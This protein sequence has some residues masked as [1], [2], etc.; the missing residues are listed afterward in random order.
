[1]RGKFISGVLGA[2]GLIAIGCGPQ[3]KLA[4]TRTI[5]EHSLPLEFRTRA[6]RTQFQAT[7]R[8]PEIVALAKRIA[9]F[10]PQAHYTA[11]GTSAQGRPLPMLVLSKTGDFTPEQHAKSGKLLALF[12]SCIHPGEC[13][14]K[15]AS[16]MLARDI[17]VTGKH[18]DLLEH[19][20]IIF[21]P[22]F[23]PDGHERFTPY[24]R[25]NQNGPH[26]QGW[27]VTAQ[28]Y[29][30]NR[31]FAKSDAVEMQAFV[32]TWN[33]WLPDMFFDNHTTNGADH[34]YIMMWAA[35]TEPPVAPQISSYLRDVLLPE[36]IPALEAGGHA[37][38]P[39]GG[40]RDR[41]DLTRGYNAYVGYTP[42]FSTGFGALHNRPT[43]LIE[44][45]AYKTY[46]QRVRATYAIMEETLR[47]MNARPAALHAAIKQ[48]DQTTIARRG[49]HGPDGKFVLRTELTSDGD[50]LTFR[51]T[52]AVRRDSVVTGA[53][54]LAY[55]GEPITVE[56]T[57]YQTTR[58]V[59]LV[60]PPAAY[61]IPPEWHDAIQRLK[62]HGLEHFELSGSTTLTVDSYRFEDVRFPDAPYEGRFS[63]SYTAVPT[64]DVRAYPAGSIVVPLNQ[65]RAKLA[66][67]LLEPNAR[68]SLI[69]WGFFN[70]IF[71]RK[72]YFESWVMEPIAAQM[73]EAD[74]ALRAEFEEQ[75]RS[76]AEFAANPRARL[77]FFYKRTRFYDQRH[78]VYPVGRLND[79]AVVN[80]LR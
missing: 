77:N 43:F 4:H 17:V 61:I 7:G 68:D 6:E 57:I 13:A 80:R 24:N 3:A 35:T 10:S 32:R 27:R 28:N 62:L 73:L 15:D 34:Q 26:E 52:R 59:D 29:N 44:A 78:N 12:L 20:N 72:E 53:N 8:Y 42:R 79:M 39:Y 69:K 65:Q 54:V 55:T 40:P 71:E 5:A 47:V 2:L 75:L 19:C 30:L 37:P 11:F 66:L 58:P 67:H 41:V 1:M 21:M 22:I 49:A 46:E 33:E 23:S 38:I 74:P 31:D 25:I 51:G 16:L 63:P 70:A 50:P 56:T 64:T 48:A 45:H 36:I 9:E 60:S 76:D 14:G 18:A